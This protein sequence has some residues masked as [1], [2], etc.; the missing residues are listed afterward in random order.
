MKKISKVLSIFFVCVLT[1]FGSASTVFAAD[2]N[3]GLCEQPIY[4]EY[5]EIEMFGINKPYNSE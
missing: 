5:N 3:M 1:L 4:F 2:Q